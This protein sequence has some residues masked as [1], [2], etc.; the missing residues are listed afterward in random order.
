MAAKSITMKTGSADIPVGK[1]AIRMM[2]LPAYFQ[3]RSEDN[4]DSST[5]RDL[6]FSADR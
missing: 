4:N 5:D 2:A 3:N 6:Q 1:S